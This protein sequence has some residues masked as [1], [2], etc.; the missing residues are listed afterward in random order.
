MKFNLTPI[1]I[2]VLLSYG[3][4]SGND[5]TRLTEEHGDEQIYNECKWLQEN[6]YLGNNVK[7]TL[8]MNKTL[9]SIINMGLEDSSPFTSKGIESYNYYKSL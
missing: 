5:L 2:S 1:Q 3:D 8:T 6:G 9:Y 7:L 4:E